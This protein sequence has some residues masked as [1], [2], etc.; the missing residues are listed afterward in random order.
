[1][2]VI[3]PMYPSEWG[4]ALFLLSYYDVN[5]TMDSDLENP[6]SLYGFVTS[7]NQDDLRLAEMAFQMNWRQGPALCTYCRDNEGRNRHSC[8]H[9]TFTSVIDRS[10]AFRLEG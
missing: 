10:N 8:G 4:D 6:E 5:L 1:M 3:Q 7:E 9:L 2:F